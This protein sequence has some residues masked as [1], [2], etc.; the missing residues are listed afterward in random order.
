MWRRS[1]TSGVTGIHKI[2]GGERHCF[3]PR[4][5]KN[6]EALEMGLVQLWWWQRRDGDVMGV[7]GTTGIGNRHRGVECFSNSDRVYF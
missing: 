5:L 4:E 1:S 2:P 6:W 7:E 3:W